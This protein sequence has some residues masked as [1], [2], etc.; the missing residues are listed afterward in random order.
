MC[1]STLCP[2]SSSTRNMALGNGSTTV[3]STSMTSSL[4]TLQVSPVPTI[5]PARA[6]H[7]S[8]TGSTQYRTPGRESAISLDASGARHPASRGSGSLGGGVHDVHL[9]GIVQRAHRDAERMRGGLRL[10]DGDPNGQELRLP[11][12]ERE[13]IGA[14]LDLRRDVGRADQ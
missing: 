5:P 13:L 3:P 8:E 1:A 4:A 9:R 2:F 6:N 14:G 10:G 7:A 12:A 11:G